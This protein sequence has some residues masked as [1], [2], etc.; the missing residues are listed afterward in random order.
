MKTGPPAES[1]NWLYFSVGAERF[2]VPVCQGAAAKSGFRLN[3]SPV[4]WNSF[5]PL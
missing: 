2:V 3:H 5:V 1:E 4:P